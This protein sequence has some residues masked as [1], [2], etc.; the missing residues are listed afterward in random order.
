MDALLNPDLRVPKVTLLNEDVTLR[1]GPRL[2]DGTD[3]EK[4]LGFALTI[5]A[6]ID[7]RGVTAGT[8]GNFRH[9]AF[10]VDLVQA[11][12]KSDEVEARLEQRLGPREGKKVLAD[13]KAIVKEVRKSPNGLVEALKK[14][15]YLVKQ[16]YS[17]CFAEVE[18][19]GHRFGEDLPDADKK[20]LTAFLATL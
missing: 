17:S 16:V 14:R 20:A 15:P 13:L 19:A 1:V 18:N 12:F 3:K 5:P 4:L 7:G 2:W 9:K 8:I 6:E 11:K 10:V